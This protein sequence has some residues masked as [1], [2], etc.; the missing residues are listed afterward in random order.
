[1]GDQLSIAFI[2]VLS[3]LMVGLLIGVIVVAVTRQNVQNSP[4][5]VS[6][7]IQ[8]ITPTVTNIPASQSIDFNNE[9]ITAPD[10]IDDIIDEAMIDNL[11]VASKTKLSRPLDSHHILSSQFNIGTGLLFGSYFTTHQD[12]MIVTCN[13]STLLLQQS[14]DVFVSKGKFRAISDKSRINSTWDYVYWLDMEQDSL[15]IQDESGQRRPLLTGIIGFD[16]YDQQLIV[17][18]KDHVVDW[19]DIYPKD[20]NKLTLT[21]IQTRTF[22]GDIYLV[23]QG[24][25]KSVVCTVDGKVFYG[26]LDLIEVTES[27]LRVLSVSW[28]DKGYQLVYEHKIDFYSFDST[29]R[30]SQLTFP[31][32]IGKILIISNFLF[33]SLPTA[34]NGDGK[35]LCVDVNTHEIHHVLH[36]NSGDFIGGSQLEGFMNGQYF[37]LFAS[38]VNDYI[39]RY[40]VLVDV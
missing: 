38:T 20:T 8:N 12:L 25:N 35:I 2:I 26:A 17:S 15:L 18:N 40:T 28:S 1:M 5:T 31:D 24:P 19:Y 30:N 13:T 3:V 27:P 22:D 39:A 11:R 32:I 21:N 36:G 7:I 16:V 10:S 6:P 33:V 29:V 9:D 4:I 37:T 34:N 14:G 23:A